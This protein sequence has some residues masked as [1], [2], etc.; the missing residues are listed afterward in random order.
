[1]ILNVLAQITDDEYKTVKQNAINMAMQLREGHYTK[2]ALNQ[3][4][5]Q[6]I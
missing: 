3:I 1:M 4:I 6:V 5:K 2:T